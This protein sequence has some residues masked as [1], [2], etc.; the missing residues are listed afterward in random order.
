MTREILQIKFWK[1]HYKKLQKSHKKISNKKY[2]KNLKT[3]M[4]TQTKKLIG[5]DKPCFIIAEIGST[6]D[7][8]FN[9]A[10]TMIDAVAETGVDAV[11]F[12]IHISEAETLRDAPMPP[13]FKGEPRYEYFIRTGFSFD[14]WR[15]LKEYTESKGLVF[16]ASSFSIEATELLEKLGVEVHKVPSG[17]VTNLPYLAH[18][19][20]TGKQIL[21]SSGMSN[22]EEL[23]LAVKTIKDNGGDLFLFQCTTEYPV[24]P[25]NVGMNVMHEMKQRYGVTVGLSDHSLHNYAAFLAV[26]EG[27]KII[28]KH[29]TISRKLYGSDAKHSMLPQEFGELVKGI[30]T[31]EAIQASEVDKD[32]IEKFKVMKEVFQKSFVTKQDILAG[33]V[34]SKEMLTTKKPGTGIE[35]KDINRVMGRVA[36]KNL[37]KNHLLTWEDLA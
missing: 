28:E 34:I 14:Q 22:W 20:K 35:P 23:D 7:G 32:D 15:E 26:A 36:S 4:Q 18:M 37:A 11:K 33:T 31:I 19:A 3:N 5:P 25:E 13:F 17:E 8:N 16:F 10:K 2:Y 1:L 27:A 6:H 30:R 12:Q 24:I 9:L 29:F 21:L